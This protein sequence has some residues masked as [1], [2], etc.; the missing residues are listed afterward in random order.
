MNRFLKLVLVPF[1]AVTLAACASQEEK[2]PASRQDM[3]QAVR[4]FVAVREL[5]PLHAIKVNNTDSIK[6]ISGDFI[7]YKGRQANYIIEFVRHCDELDDYP[8]ITPDRRWDLKTL[9]TGADTIRGCRIENIYAL[10]EAELLEL[11]N[12]GDVPGEHG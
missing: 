7:L 10:T 1:V 11:M 8:V 9:R 2:P 5:E 6:K 4:D 12:I 3:T